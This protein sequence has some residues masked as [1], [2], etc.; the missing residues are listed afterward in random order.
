MWR[1]L[2]GLG[3]LVVAIALVASGC[4]GVDDAAVD[5]AQEQADTTVVV[6]EPADAG[7]TSTTA[8]EE[9]EALALREDDSGADEAP[10]TTAPAGTTADAATSSAEVLPPIDEL[11][12]GLAEFADC[13]ND[14]GVEVAPFT[15]QDM[16]SKAAGMPLVDSRAEMFGF[17]LDT[18]GTDPAFQAAVEV[19]NPIVDAIPGLGA[20]LPAS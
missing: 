17:F 20:F 1:R 15:L 14:N 3:R 4:G 16:I 5:E 13:L 9:P 2:Y 6:D 18:D 12:A 19:C 10:G 8:D 11:D 7:T